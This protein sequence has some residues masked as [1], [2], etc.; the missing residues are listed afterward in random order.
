MGRE[1]SGETIAG[2]VGGSNSVQKTTN[3]QLGR[4]S[5]QSSM[6]VIMT[7]SSSEKKDNLGWNED[8]V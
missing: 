8:G 4:F 7:G 3:K 6:T 1:L 5:C 2:D